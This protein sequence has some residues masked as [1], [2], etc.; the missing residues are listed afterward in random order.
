[1]KVCNLSMLPVKMAAVAAFALLSPR[2]Y[3]KILN[4]Q[5]VVLYEERS[6]HSSVFNNQFMYS[7]YIPHPQASTMKSVYVGICVNNMCK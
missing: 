6:P 7:H 4:C 2:S 3:T 5:R 1:M